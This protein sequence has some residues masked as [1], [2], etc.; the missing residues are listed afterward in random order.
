MNGT[1]AGM[2]V[3]TPGAGCQPE[4][5]KLGLIVLSG[6]SVESTTG[7]GAINLSANMAGAAGLMHQGDIAGLAHPRAVSPRWHCSPRER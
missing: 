7:G 5:W 1:S 2:N 6:V 4:S 3:Q